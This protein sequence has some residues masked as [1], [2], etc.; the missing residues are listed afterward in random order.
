VAKEDDELDGD[1][2]P[3]ISGDSDQEDVPKRAAGESVVSLIDSWRSQMPAWLNAGLIS[4][5]SDTTQHRIDG[6]ANLQVCPRY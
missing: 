1:R 4:D 3:S 6:K 5:T 2:D